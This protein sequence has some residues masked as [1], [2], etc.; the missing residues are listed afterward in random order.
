MHCMRV[1]NVFYD[2][3]LQRTVVRYV[4]KIV[5]VWSGRTHYV[6]KPIVK[7]REVPVATPSGDVPA[8]IRPQLTDGQLLDMFLDRA[9]RGDPGGE[10]K[11]E[12]ETCQPQFDQ[13][14]NEKVTVS[15]FARL[16]LQTPTQMRDIFLS[17]A[18]DGNLSRLQKM[19]EA[20]QTRLPHFPECREL[21]SE[22]LKER[23]RGQKAVDEL[24][25]NA[26]M[27]S[28]S[29]NQA[30]TL[31]Q[32]AVV[33]VGIPF[34][35]PLTCAL[36]ESL[37]GP[38]LYL[39]VQTSISFLKNLPPPALAHETTAPLLR[40]LKALSEFAFLVARIRMTIELFFKSAPTVIIFSSPDSEEAKLVACRIVKG[41]PDFKVPRQQEAPVRPP[42]PLPPPVQ[43]PPTVQELKKGYLSWGPPPSNM[44]FLDGCVRMLASQKERLANRE[45]LTGSET[46]LIYRMNKWRENIRRLEEFLSTCRETKGMVEL[47]PEGSAQRSLFVYV[48]KNYMEETEETDE[49]GYSSASESR[50]GASDAGA[51]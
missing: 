35:A 41:T 36:R 1:R 32:V 33:C 48:E 43:R 30:Q 10:D 44:P 19:V 28:V 21:I 51:I 29:V 6:V 17:R 9:V 46:L 4:P 34:A 38:L 22:A 37:G 39:T 24:R 40:L 50:A 18:F 20:F 14:S 27:R 5:R 47:P 26:H 23:V 45:S 15:L 42:L 3:V 49:G 7:I 12:G 25:V 31:G 2:V 11:D 13:T 16:E 8:A